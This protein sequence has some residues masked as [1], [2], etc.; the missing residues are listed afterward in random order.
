MNEASRGINPRESGYHPAVT[1]TPTATCAGRWARMR[2]RAK[3]TSVAVVDI[4]GEDDG[5]R[6]ARRHQGGNYGRRPGVTLLLSQRQFGAAQDTLVALAQQAA[7]AGYE[8]HAHGYQFLADTARAYSHLP[9]AP[10][11]MGRS[12]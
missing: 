11:W 3:H 5:S 12:P 2:S 9:L 4:M 10:D 1:P 6:F 8:T 7:A